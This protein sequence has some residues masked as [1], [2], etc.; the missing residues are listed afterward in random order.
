[1]LTK[2]ISKTELDREI[3]P[4]VARFCAKDEARISLDTRVNL[5]LGVD[6]ADADDLLTL[7][8]RE[9]GWPLK[10][11]RY[12]EHFVPES[13]FSPFAMLRALFHGGKT[14]KP[15]TIGMLSQLYFESQP[16]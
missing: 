16:K 2:M 11:F 7:I 1:M 13:E 5:D 12:D 15:L 6:G 3:I 10:D 9:L 4:L 8:S 14:L